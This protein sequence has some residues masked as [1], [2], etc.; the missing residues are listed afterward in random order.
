MK[1]NFKIEYQEIIIVLAILF[2]TIL[3]DY[4]SI[5]EYIIKIVKHSRWIQL[6][7]V[8][9]VSLSLIMSYKGKFDIT[10]NY[11]LNALIITLLFSLITKPKPI[12]EKKIKKIEKNINH[13]VHDMKMKNEIAK[14][15]QK[16]TSTSL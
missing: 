1:L 11:I 14:E 4:V 5:E 15:Q 2:F 7:C 9:V 12:L 3:S 8:F 6:L 10:L 16:L 13:K